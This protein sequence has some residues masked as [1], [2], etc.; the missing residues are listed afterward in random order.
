[1]ALQLAGAIWILR[2]G[3]AEARGCSPLL[4]LVAWAAMVQAAQLVVAFGLWWTALRPGGGPLRPSVTLVRA[5]LW[6]A[7]PFAAASLLGAIQLRSS[8]LLLGYLRGPAE[9]G[10]FAAAWRFSEAAKLIPNGIFNAAFSAFAAH[11][12]SAGAGVLFR[13]FQRVLA[14]LAVGLALLLVV[15]AQPVLHLTFGPEFLPAASTLVWLGIG[16]VP[17]LWNGAMEVYLYA[18]GDEAYAARLGALGTLV[19]VAAS[20]PLIAGLGASGAAI[21]VVLGEVVLWLPLRARTLSR[22]AETKSAAEA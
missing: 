13:A 7:A 3:C 10:L 8:P 19:Q 21:A 15:F 1:L 18:A 11:A 6:R 17:A 5:M 12:Q 4:A 20:L 2:S 16:L 9:V 22:L 14:V